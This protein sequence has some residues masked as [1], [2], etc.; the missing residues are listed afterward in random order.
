[1]Y[2]QV[3]LLNLG[4]PSGFL[5]NTVQ[6]PSAGAVRTAVKHLQ[7][8]QALDAKE[9]LTPLG[10]HL[11]SLPVEPHVAK[12]RSKNIACYVLGLGVHVG[13]IAFYALYFGLGAHVG[14]PVQGGFIQHHL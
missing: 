12:V 7:I 4:T 8:L 5:N 10:F 9:E 2:S 1:M 3:R 14:A 6:P 13:H 11:A